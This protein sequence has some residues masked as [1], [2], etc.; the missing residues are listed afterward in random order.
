MYLKVCR[1][2]IHSYSS[3]LQNLAKKLYIIYNISFWLQECLLVPLFLVVTIGQCLGNIYIPRYNQILPGRIV[4]ATYLPAYMWQG[5]PMGYA[6][7]PKVNIVKPYHK[8]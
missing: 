6:S 3:I 4:P 8:H 7:L 1:V 2:I 5:M